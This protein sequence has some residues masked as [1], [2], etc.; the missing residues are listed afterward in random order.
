MPFIVAHDS[1]RVILLFMRVAKNL[2]V[3][4]IVID[5]ISV[6]HPAKLGGEC[7][8]VGEH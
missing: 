4:N 3:K 7:G 5:L 8:T 2:A 6:L 1:M